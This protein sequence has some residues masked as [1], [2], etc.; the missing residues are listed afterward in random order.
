MIG[1]SKKPQLSGYVRH[2]ASKATIQM[3]LHNPNGPN[4]CVTREI[5]LDNKSN[6]KLQG[7]PASHT[8][9]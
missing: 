9:V 1:Q 5:T 4:Y 7:K 8:Q 6:W 2:G 3:E